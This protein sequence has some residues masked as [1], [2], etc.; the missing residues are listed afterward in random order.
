MLT[1]AGEDAAEGT[2]FGR[3]RLI[4]LL[5]RGGMGEVWRAHDTV[6]DRVVAIKVLPANLSEH[7]DFQRRFRREA[8]AAP[9]LDTPH[10]VP[11]HDF[12][13]IDGRLFVSMRLI[14]GRDLQ[15]L[16]ADGPLDP[17]RAVRIVDQVARALH[18]AHDV[19]LIHRDIKPSNILLDDDDFA[20]LIDF[21]I[22]RAADETRMTK[23]GYAIG[24]FAYIAPERLGTRAHEDA[25]ADIYSLACVLYECLTGGPPFDADTIA[26]LVAAH[27]HTPPPRPSATRPNV[28]KQMD[29][30]IAKGMAKDPDR[31][32]Q[33]ALQFARSAQSALTEPVTADGPESTPLDVEFEVLEDYLTSDQRR[34][35]NRVASVAG[36]PGVKKG[37]AVMAIAVAAFIVVVLGI[38]IATP[39]VKQES[40]SSTPQL[41]SQAPTSTSGSALSLPPVIPPATPAT[42]PAAATQVLT[43]IAVNANGQPINGYQE[44]PPSTDDTLIGCS[45]PSTTSR[46]TGVYDCLPEAADAGTCWPGKLRFM[47]CLANNDPWKK[48]LKRFSLIGTASLDTLSSPFQARPLALLLDDGTRCTYISHGHFYTTRDDGYYG[49]YNCGSAGAI[50]ARPNDSEQIDQSQPLWTVKV[51]Q[52]GTSC[53]PVLGTTCM[54]FPP[55]ETHTVVN[56]WFAGT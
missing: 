54:H 9:R 16:L 10:V 6:T 45:T 19:G 28:P 7:R 48:M 35:K 15:T 40:P 46:T 30:V 26:G 51:G 21:G 17:A 29:E 12:G 24:T 38:V 25:R 13:E 56:A 52:V 8:H 3:Y 43:S 50:L 1:V 55:P 41:T 33:T 37:T 44:L 14:K 47:L 2:P 27:L 22:A 49:P 4:S 5:G 18:A 23:S 53:D 39:R 36:R 32:Y 42:P 34:S 31:R 20:Y 11:I